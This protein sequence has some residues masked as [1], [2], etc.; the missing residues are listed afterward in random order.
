MKNFNGKIIL[1]N[2]DKKVKNAL[3]F[4]HGYG[5]NADDLIGIGIDFKKKFQ[6][7]VFV[8]PN[9]PFECEWGNNSYQW[10]DLTSIAP[11]KI[12]EG[13]LK[14]GPYLNDLIEKVKKNFS[15]NDKQIIFFGFSQ[16]AM[17]GLYHL[18][19]RNNSCAGLLAFSGLLFEDLNFEKEIVSR[20][21]VA[22]YHGKNDEVIDYKNSLKSFEILRK[23]GFDSHYHIQ[24]N[25]GHGIDN[26]GLEFA[27]EFIEKILK[28]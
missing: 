17:M 12:G 1:P 10:F 14:A 13:L 24:N 20:F 16:G 4:L 2:S 28:I 18:C 22:L 19:K 15:L 9:A 27:L 6:N 11:E 23:L 25:L 26:D 5:A 21:P 8:S 7:T 3:I